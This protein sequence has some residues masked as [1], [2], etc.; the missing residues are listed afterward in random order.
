[1]THD[2]HQLVSEEGDGSF[3]QWQ[4]MRAQFFELSMHHPL[5]CS[6]LE[7]QRVRVVSS[8]R[9]TQ[10]LPSHCSLSRSFRPT[11]DRSHV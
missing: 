2:W 3:N 8:A 11:F 5:Q 10:E 4:E 1:M 7:Q 6:L 9:V